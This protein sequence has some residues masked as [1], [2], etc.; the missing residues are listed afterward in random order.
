[1]WI[2][3]CGPVA[4]TRTPTFAEL[5]RA[6]AQY[7]RRRCARIYASAHDAHALRKC[8]ELSYPRTRT[9]VKQERPKKIRS[10]FSGGRALGDV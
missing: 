8:H 9:D 10:D 6:A 2:Q 4:V 7:R 1:M 3:F 5:P